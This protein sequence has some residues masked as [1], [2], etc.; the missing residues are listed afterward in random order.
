MGNNGLLTF[1]LKC[2]LLKNVSFDKKINFSLLSKEKNNK[3]EL[4]GKLFLI[5]GYSQ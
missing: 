4:I 5:Y 3:T 1:D 2:L